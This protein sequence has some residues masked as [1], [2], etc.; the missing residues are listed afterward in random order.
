MSDFSK[1]KS[2]GIQFYDVGK[3]MVDLDMNTYL[4]LEDAEQYVKQRINHI[5]A[6]DGPLFFEMKSRFDY[7][8]ENEKVL[9]QRIKEIQDLLFQASDNKDLNDFFDFAFNR[10]NKS[11]SDKIWTT[12]KTHDGKSLNPSTQKT[13]IA[14]FYLRSVSELM[15]FILR[16]YYENKFGDFELNPA[17]FES[18]PIE[19]KREKMFYLSKQ[20]KKILIDE[21]KKILQSKGLTINEDI[22]ETMYLT[23]IL[24]FI[25]FFERKEILAMRIL[26]DKSADLLDSYKKID[27]EARLFI[28]PHLDE[29]FDLLDKFVR[30]E[31]G[32]E[33]LK[34]FK[35]QFDEADSKNRAMSPEDDIDV[36]EFVLKSQIP[37]PL[38]QFMATDGKPL[39]REDLEKLPDEL[40]T[41]D[42]LSKAV[43]VIFNLEFSK[44][45]QQFHQL[46]TL[47]NFN[48][49][50]TDEE[51]TEENM[52]R[53][54]KFA[55][56]SIFKQEE[57]IGIQSKEKQ[58]DTIKTGFI[59]DLLE[60]KMIP[61][62]KNVIRDY[63]SEFVLWVGIYNYIQ[64]KFGR[65]NSQGELV[66]V[67]M[68]NYSD[69][70][71]Y[72]TKNINYFLQSIII[73]GLLARKSKYH[74]YLQNQNDERNL[75]KTCFYQSGV[76][77]TIKY[78][79]YEDLINSIYYAVIFEKGKQIFTLEES[80]KSRI[81]NNQIIMAFMG[82]D[83]V[84]EYC[85]RA[86][87]IEKKS[88]ITVA[89]KEKKEKEVEVQKRKQEESEAAFKELMEEEEKEKSGSKQ[90][91]SKKKKKGTRKKKPTPSERPSTV[92]APTPP[93]GDTPPPSS[94]PV[95]PLMSQDLDLKQCANYVPWNKLCGTTK[96]KQKYNKAF[97]RW[98][99]V[100][101][102]VNYWKNPEEQEEPPIPTSP[103]ESIIAFLG[104][105]LN[106]YSKEFAIKGGCIRDIIKSSKVNDVDIIVYDN[107][108][109][110]K[111]VSA[112]GEKLEEWNKITDSKFAIDGRPEAKLFKY[113]LTDS[114]GKLLIIEIG[115]AIDFYSG[116][117]KQ[118]D[119]LDAFDLDINQLKLD[120]QNRA[121]G[122][123]GT[124]LTFQ[125]L[126]YS[127]VSVE[128]MIKNI[129][130]SEAVILKRPTTLFKS[131][132]FNQISKIINRVTKNRII[133]RFP[134]YV[135]EKYGQE[136][137]DRMIA[138]IYYMAFRRVG[139]DKEIGNEKLVAEKNALF[140]KIP[141]E[142]VKDYD[143][144]IRLLS[145]KK[146]GKTRKNRK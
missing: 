17:S 103:Y 109:Y 110:D 120:V 113:T 74:D 16:K 49:E 140:E 19:T 75:S 59:G 39:G 34:V 145:R 79:S 70:I 114:S 111:L 91:T 38:N 60:K 71:E 92:P 112:I 99:K 98:Y 21:I 2:V 15:N 123:I 86:F 81:I 129:T 53:L 64:S 24:R 30:F 78:G 13:P 40:S 93:Q 58:I 80:D 29:S 25:V 76:F 4:S 100:I 66:N 3:D 94:T 125:D 115:K 134:K 122:Y 35:K 32:F 26:K 68:N 46:D 20:L 69:M 36:E 5:F 8:P 133:V 7:K 95:P 136:V 72:I 65:A 57:F 47:Y 132:T 139:E 87:I 14:A 108:Q 90:P 141:I 45:G 73:S 42:D 102:Q 105:S 138:Y 55:Q 44:Y 51:G 31:D 22:V 118:P 130:D 48:S 137:V 119:S 54:L 142:K 146:G 83:S 96:K 124:T 28:K 97:D 62:K 43:E 107:P 41:L 10:W 27:E 88:D 52:L 1:E 121:T 9:L 23:V 6:L 131:G 67:K 82:I 126:T 85:I 89:N 84:I 128:G 63:V 18:M 77:F 33:K 143:E 12:V 135:V 106:K 144:I 127:K 117:K 104:V 116:T 37:P 11:W 56:Y 61:V 101:E 50:D